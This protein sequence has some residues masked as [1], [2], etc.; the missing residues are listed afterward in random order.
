MKVVWKVKRDSG[1]T[2]RQAE[3]HGCMVTVHEYGWRGGWIH[4]LVRRDKDGRHASEGGIC[5][6]AV[7]GKRRALA[8]ARRIERR[9]AR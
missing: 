4:V 3:A 7:A 8:L 5:A 1:T 2:S 9:A 6:D